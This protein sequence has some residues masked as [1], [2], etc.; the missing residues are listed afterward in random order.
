ML[1]L[2]FNNNSANFI[3]KCDKILQERI[4]EKLKKRSIPAVKFLSVEIVNYLKKHNM[5]K[6]EKPTEIYLREIN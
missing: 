3:K 5:I 6:K 2:V 1:N 4:L